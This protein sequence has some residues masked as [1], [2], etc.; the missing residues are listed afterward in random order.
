MK[1]VIAVSLLFLTAC[2][3]NSLKTVQPTLDINQFLNKLTAL[4]S[5]KTGQIDRIVLDSFGLDLSTVA[6][7]INS[8]TKVAPNPQ[9]LGITA[10]SYQRSEAAIEKTTVMIEEVMFTLHPMLLCVDTQ[11]LYNAWRERVKAGTLSEIRF[12]A[13]KLWPN[14]GL[15]KNQDEK[16]RRGNGP[17]EMIVDVL[18][19]NNALYK[20][21]YIFDHEYHRCARSVVVRVRQ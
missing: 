7:D 18:D 10:I 12:G 17:I 8:F 5:A 19:S 21:S 3:S 16:T 9:N 11:T 13:G 4:P 14:D 20:T 6:P 2:A 15:H 1:Q